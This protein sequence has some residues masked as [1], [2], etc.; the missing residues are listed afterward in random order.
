MSCVDVTKD[1]LNALHSTGCD[2]DDTVT[3]EYAAYMN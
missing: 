1:Y 2:G 3:L